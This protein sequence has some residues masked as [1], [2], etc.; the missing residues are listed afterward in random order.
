[1]S[2]RIYSAINYWP[3]SSLLRRKYAYTTSDQEKKRKKT[4]KFR[5]WFWKLI[6]REIFWDTFISFITHF[7]NCPI[8]HLKMH[9]NICN[10]YVLGQWEQLLQLQGRPWPEGDSHNVVLY[11]YEHWV[12]VTVIGG[13]SKALNSTQISSRW[14]FLFHIFSGDLFLFDN[15]HS[16]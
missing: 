2:L 1:M 6:L 14:L 8:W 4:F 7:F 5:E 9:R 16:T 10:C 12:D 13:N 15:I 3:S 11:M